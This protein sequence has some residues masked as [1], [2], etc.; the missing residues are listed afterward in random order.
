VAALLKK[1]QQAAMKGKHEKFKTATEYDT[2]AKHPEYL[3]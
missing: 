3:G 2:T 1:T